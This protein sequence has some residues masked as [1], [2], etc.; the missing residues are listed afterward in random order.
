MLGT[1]ITEAIFITRTLS[2]ARAT[3]TS[4]VLSAVSKAQQLVPGRP[5]YYD[6]SFTTKIYGNADLLKKRLKLVKG[7]FGVA[8]RG[9]Q[10]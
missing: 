4:S 7:L 2:N 3:S 1:T 10:V 5:L 9:K 6:P 8:N